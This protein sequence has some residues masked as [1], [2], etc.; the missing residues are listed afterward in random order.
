MSDADSTVIDTFGIRNANIPQNHD[1]YGVPYPGMYLVNKSG[2]VFDKHFVSD[3]SVRESAHSALQ[4]RFAVDIDREGLA[5]TV[6]RA[7]GVTARAWFTSPTIRVAQMTVL[8]VELELAPGLHV[9]GRPLP[10]GYIPVYLQVD[11]GDDLEVKEIVYPPAQP[12]NFAVIGETLPAYTGHVQI[13][14]HYVGKAYEGRVEVQVT[15]RYQACDEIRCH[16]PE[17]IAFVL[18]L[19]VLTHDFERV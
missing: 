3:H 17:R 19:E 14:A 18:P 15:L 6:V 1:W 13:K 12:Q 5:L 11:G 4:E 16:L 10:E 9:Y 2:R 8:T 7:T